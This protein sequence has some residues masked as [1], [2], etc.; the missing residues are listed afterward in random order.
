M[1]GILILKCLVLIAFISPAAAA[2]GKFVERYDDWSAY[3]GEVAANKVCFAISQPKDTKPKNVRRGP[4]YFYVS[5]WPGEKVRNEISIKIGYPFRDGVP[6]EVSIGNDK[7]KF[8]TID[9]GAFVESTETEKR[10]IKTMKVGN[11]MI[12][13]GRSKRGTLTTDRYSLNGITAA[14]AR[15][16]KDCP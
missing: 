9:E 11:E 4:I 5:N 14:L 2:T 6:S 12:V 10:I 13:Q 16:S 3:V 8:F 7:F 1:R 15:I